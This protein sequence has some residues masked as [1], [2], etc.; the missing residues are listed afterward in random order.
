MDIT[1]IEMKELYERGF[2][3]A[4]NELSPFKMATIEDSQ[5]D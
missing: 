1:V 4:G 2:L 3:K 5:C